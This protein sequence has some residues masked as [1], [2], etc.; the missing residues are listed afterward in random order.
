M[1]GMNGC[2]DREEKSEDKHCS[3][4]L[5]AIYLF[6]ELLHLS[7]SDAEVDVG[8]KQLVVF[9][10]R[11]KLTTSLFVSAMATRNEQMCG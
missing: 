3:I 11:G 8:N 7:A 10:C 9:Q 4:E 6:Q 5:E 2:I 1:A